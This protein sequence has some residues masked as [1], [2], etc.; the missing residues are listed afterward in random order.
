[1]GH[2]IAAVSGVAITKLFMLRSDFDD[3]RWVAGAVTCS[4]ASALMTLTNTVHPPGG[5]TALLAAVDPTVSA[6]GWIFVPLA[7]LGSTIMIG[8]ALLVNNIQRQFPTYWWTPKDVGRQKKEDLES[9]TEEKKDL[10]VLEGRV[11]KER[12]HFQPTITLSPD[13]ITLPEDLALGQMETEVLEVI[14]D[15]LRD[16]AR[17]GHGLSTVSSVGSEGTS[18]TK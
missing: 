2:A 13:D 15:R 1:M 5:A 10:A 11:E 17:R 16:M 4:V 14:R 18:E 3:L 7:L 9:A 8:V 6:L 12:R